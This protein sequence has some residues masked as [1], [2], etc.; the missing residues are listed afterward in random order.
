M[1]PPEI[2]ETDRLR[3]RRSLERDAEGI[4]AA[5]AQDR[6]VT[7]YLAWRPT[8]NIEDTRESLRH[9]ANE[10]QEGSAFRWTI[11]RKKDDQLLGT[12]ALRVDGPKVELGYVLAKKFWGKGLTT[13]A[14]RA[15]VD[16]ALKEDGVYR[17]W[18]VCD[19]ENPASAR[20]LEKAGME[21][22]GLLRRWSVHPTRSSEP[23]DCYCYA[24]TK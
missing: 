2:I 5:Y 14:V 1:T 18:A 20:V 10:W 22:E 21:R 24:I 15:I 12:L 7:M 6:E 4:F 8:G 17:V 9:A 16:W 23:R 19:V 11:F 3:L 13:E